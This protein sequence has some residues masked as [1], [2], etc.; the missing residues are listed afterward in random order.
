[1]RFQFASRGCPAAARQHNV[2]INLQNEVGKT[3]LYEAL[4]YYAYLDE[5]V[6]VYSAR[7]LVLERV[8]E[9]DP[10]IRDAACTRLHCIKP[11]PWDGSR[12]LLYYGEKVYERGRQGIAPF[13]VA[14]RQASP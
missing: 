4:S 11:R 14:P 6:A 7:R 2:R 10:N 9:S 8:A 3:P 12:S 1:M 5:K 13:Q